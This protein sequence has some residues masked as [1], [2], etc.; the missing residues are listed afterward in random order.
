M[1]ASSKSKK[2][3]TIFFFLQSVTKREKKFNYIHDQPNGRR[4]SLPIYKLKIL[5]Q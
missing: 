3:V 1:F 5:G 2:F 4:I